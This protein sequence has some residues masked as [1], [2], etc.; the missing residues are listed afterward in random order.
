MDEPSYIFGNMAHLF[1]PGNRKSPDYEGEFKR[2]AKELS[3]QSR[4]PDGLFS[5]LRE[6]QLFWAFLCLDLGGY[7]SWKSNWLGLLW[8][9]CRTGR[10]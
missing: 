1:L 10:R 9:A 7:A 5:L 4:V 6:K 2:S 8:E 3:F